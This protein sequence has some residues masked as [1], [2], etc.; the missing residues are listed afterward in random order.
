MF[1]TAQI[2]PSLSLCAGCGILLILFAY[3]CLRER[4]PAKMTCSATYKILL[5]EIRLCANTIALVDIAEKCD[6]FFCQFEGHEL[7]FEL[8]TD[9]CEEMD[10]RRELLK[11]PRKI[12]AVS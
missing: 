11:A 8:Y 1:L 12:Q 5:L 6:N 10:L 7:M 9:L 4:K 2:V 3:A